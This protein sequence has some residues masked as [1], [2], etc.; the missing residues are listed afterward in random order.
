MENNPWH[1]LGKQI[2]DTVRITMHEVSTSISMATGGTN[3]TTVRSQTQGP[4]PPTGTEPQRGPVYTAEPIEPNAYNRPLN[5]TS[6]PLWKPVKNEPGRFAGVLQIGLGITGALLSV[7]GLLTVGL[8]EVVGFFGNA[9]FFPMT[10]LSA[11]TVACSAITVAGI[12]KSGL[13]G[14]AKRM[15]T[16]LETKK[17]CTLAQLG[18]ITGRSPAKT[19]QDLRKAMQ[20]G[21]LPNVRMDVAE[22]CA[23][24]GE[25]TYRLYLDSEAERRRREHEDAERERT[26]GQEGS[27]RLE[28]FSAEGDYALVVLREVRAH[29]KKEEVALNIRK[30]EQTVEKIFTYVKQH[31]NKLPDTRKFT[32]YYLPTTIKVLQKYRQYDAMEVQLDT[33]KTAMKEIEDT[34]SK[35]NTSYINLLESLYHEDTL[36]VTTDIEVLQSMLEQEGFAKGEFQ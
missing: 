16:L 8:M 33:V 11:S 1:N 22:T 15:R 29:V 28:Q 35:L 20:A 10:V 27:A 12:K 14:R 31:P 26:L 13:S 30:I 4:P 3:K 18:E 7:F 5:R 6:A 17:V 36:D 24:F 25:E 9:L 19:K 2:G 23:I 21:Y 34:L 32:S